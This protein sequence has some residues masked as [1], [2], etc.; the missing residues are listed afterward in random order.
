MSKKTVLI[1]DDDQDIIETTGALLE[2]EGFSI[3]SA[4]TVEEG[5]QKIGI[6]KPDIILLDIMFPEKKT[7]GFE[8][9]EEIKKLYPDIPIIAFSAINREYAFDFSKEDIK[10]E[11]FVNKPVET[12]KLVEMINKYTQK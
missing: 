5:I 8:A 1:I 6:I 11:D 9:A 7:R 3:H 10:A 2:F 12:D 4:E